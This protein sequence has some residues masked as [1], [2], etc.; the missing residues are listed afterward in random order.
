MEIAEQLRHAHRQSPAARAARETTKMVLEAGLPAVVL[1]L[2]GG[3]WLMR[4][5]LAPVAR[6]TRAMEQIHDATGRS[7]SPLGQWR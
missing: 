7:A 3:W 1:G 2:A 4:R 5:A 6:L